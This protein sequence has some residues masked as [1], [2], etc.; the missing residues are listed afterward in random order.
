MVVA[1]VKQAARLGFP[2]GQHASRDPFAVELGIG[3]CGIVLCQI[4]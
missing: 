1:D 2:R 4:G 3:Q